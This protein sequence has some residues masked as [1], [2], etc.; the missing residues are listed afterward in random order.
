V[1]E[2]LIAP[3]GT[4][5][6]WIASTVE[7]TYWSSACW[8]M[9]STSAAARRSTDRRKTYG[10][11]LTRRIAAEAEALF[12]RFISGTREDERM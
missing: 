4:R 3:I 6:D 8:G 11:L 1:A 2:W 9:F 12:A 10:V 5:L 7:G